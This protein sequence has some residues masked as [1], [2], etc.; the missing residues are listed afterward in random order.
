M[1]AGIGFEPMTK[2][3]T[4]TRSTPELTSQN[5]RIGKINL[6]SPQVGGGSWIRTNNNQSS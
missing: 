3:L 5:E 1:E 2:W 4:A 6:F